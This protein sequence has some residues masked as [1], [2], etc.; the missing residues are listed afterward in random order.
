MLWN[1]GSWL[2]HGSPRNCSLITNLSSE[3]G[4]LPADYGHSSRL[5]DSRHIYRLMI[6]ARKIEM[7][8]KVTSAG[9]PG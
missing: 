2:R 4:L 1:T 9:F 6:I 3:V 7:Y 8:R 5:G